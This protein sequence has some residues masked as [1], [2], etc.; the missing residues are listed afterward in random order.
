[1]T[2]FENHVSILFKKM[3]KP[4][5]EIMHAAIGVAGE[6]GEILDAVKK[7]WAYNKELD[8]TNVIE[9]LG[10]L[11]FYMEALRQKLNLSREMILNHNI[12]KLSVRYP[13]GYSDQAAQ[14]RADKTNRG[15]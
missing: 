5:D 11:E 8:L 4:E 6:G 3:D 7:M 13:K 9:E 14:E 1:M 15:N 2:T 12:A 10:D